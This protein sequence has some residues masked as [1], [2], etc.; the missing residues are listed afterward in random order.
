MRSS[1]L[2]VPLLGVSRD[3]HRAGTLLFVPEGGISCVIL[4]CPFLTKFILAKRMENEVSV[5]S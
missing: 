2:S 5:A 3:D 4:V 1:P